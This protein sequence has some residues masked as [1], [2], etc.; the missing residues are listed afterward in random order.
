MGPSWITVKNAAQVSA[1]VTWGRFQVSVE[2]MTDISVMKDAPPA[3][4]L[5]VLSLKVIDR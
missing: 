1:Q 2:S 3:P 4:A 5:S